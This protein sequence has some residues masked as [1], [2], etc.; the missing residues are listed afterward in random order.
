MRKLL[1]RKVAVELAIFAA[2]I[3]AG[4]TG[5]YHCFLKEPL[6]DSWLARASVADIDA[7]IQEALV[8]AI[9]ARPFMAE[10]MAA[11][12]D[13]KTGWDRL[14][15]CEPYCRA[16]EFTDAGV[17]SGKL[18]AALEWASNAKEEWHVFVL[19]AADRIVAHASTSLSA[20]ERPRP[21][22][23]MLRQGLDTTNPADKRN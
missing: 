1:H 13:G 10:G 20:E 15:V 11:A 9:G 6:A 12:I 19:D 14:I 7:G 16:S 4:G 23:I 18:A 17:S 8:S 2:V 5:L 21:A 3:I 22:V